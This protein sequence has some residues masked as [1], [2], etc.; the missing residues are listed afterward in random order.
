MSERQ[1]VLIV[2]DDGILALDLSITLSREGWG[3]I[4]MARNGEVAMRHFRNGNRP[5]LILMDINLGKGMDGIATAECIRDI[6]ADVVIV[7]HTAHADAETRSRAARV[8][9]YAVVEKGA[10]HSTLVAAL[11]GIKPLGLTA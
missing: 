1:G 6:D 4:V 11:A 8:R 7:F 2:E 10:T 9:P 5:A 3:K